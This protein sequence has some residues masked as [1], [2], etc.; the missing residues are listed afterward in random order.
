MSKPLYDHLAAAALAAF[1]AA[2]G[3]G[4]IAVPGAAQADAPSV[5]VVSPRTASD[6][7]GLYEMSNGS[8]L[9]LRF[10]AGRLLASFDDGPAYQLLRERALR[11]QFRSAD[12]AVRLRFEPGH[13]GPWSVVTAS[14]RS[15]SRP[16]AVQVGQP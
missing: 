10:S 9:E 15:A 8:T 5:H 3:A 11:M 14:L 1:A 6:V 7:T 2:L 12:D 13:A 4:C 16:N